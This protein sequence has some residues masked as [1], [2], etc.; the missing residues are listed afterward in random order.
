MKRQICFDSAK[1]F[2]IY[3]VV[4]CHCISYWGWHNEA[5]I[6]YIGSYFMPIFFFVSGYFGYKKDLRPY[7]V[8]KKRFIELIVPYITV[9]VLINSIWCLLFDKP[10]WIHYILDESKGG[11]WFLLVLFFFFLIYALAKAVSSR[12]DK[13]MFS[14][15]IGAYLIIFVLVSVLPTDVCW[16]FSLMSVRKFMPIFIAGLLVRKF[17]LQIRPWSTTV[18]IIA[19]L[20]YISTTAITFCMMGKTYISMLLWSI[21]AIFGPIFY[22]NVF[23]RVRGFAA[24]S[25]WGRYSLTI[26]IYHFIIIYIHK[27]A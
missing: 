23:K 22:L 9:G 4:L 5:L 7:V 20:F 3:S 25:F 2:A 24:L 21:G 11:F 10:F 12:K 1:G 18:F 27:Y 19:A 14:I 13:V 26:Y 17:E 15:L 16:L 8:V 6:H